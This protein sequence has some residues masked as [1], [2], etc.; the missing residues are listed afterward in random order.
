MKVLFAP[1][2]HRAHLT[3]GPLRAAGVEVQAVRHRPPGT[4]ARLSLACRTAL[5]TLSSPADI[6]LTDMCSSLAL[7]P[8]LP[9]DLRR[10]PLVLR[11]QSDSWREEQDLHLQGK[12]GALRSILDPGLQNHFYRKAAAILAVSE[13]LK[14]PIV[15]NAGVEPDNITA[16]PPP[17]DATRFAPADD[18]EAVKREL[19]F[20]HAH[21]ISAVVMFK[22]VQ[23]LAGLE[24]FLPIL[25]AV[26]E[27][28][29]DV[30]VVIAGDGAL[31]SEFEQ[32]NWQWLDHPRMILPGYLDKI[33][34]VYQCSDTFVH[35][36]LFDAC[37]N[38]LLEA[39]ACEKPVVVNDYAPLLANL[40]PAVNGYLI[41][42][43]ADVE[44]AVSIFEPL[45]YDPEHR[46]E[47]GRRGRS[48]VVEQFSEA[49]IG[50][51]FRE[52]FERVV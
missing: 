33:E 32:R 31:R 38:V 34:K 36:S 25:R 1:A 28:H 40:R 51:R 39:W 18:P 52:V 17:V 29:S 42:G 16:I 26:V 41:R 44:E 35:F 20:D 15:R 48:M 23:K 21:I 45:L 27:K 19:G 46:R 5:A 24:H 6:L 3:E 13:S 7:L 50:Q 12:A 10:R 14:E 49:A 9:G 2:G 43:D 30:A 8:T 4:L 22:F 47:L 37:P 11:A